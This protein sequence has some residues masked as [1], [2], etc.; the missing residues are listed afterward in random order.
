LSHECFPNSFQNLKPK[1]ICTSQLTG[2]CLS[3][4]ILKLPKSVSLGFSLRALNLSAKCRLLTLPASNS[5]MINASVLRSRP[6]SNRYCKDDLFCFTNVTI[7]VPWSDKG[8]SHA[9]SNSKLR[10]A[11][12][13]RLHCSGHL[14]AQHSNLRG[15]LRRSYKVP[16]GAHGRLRNRLA[17]SRETKP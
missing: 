3:I 4:V 8:G 13:Y 7:T 15:S 5:S 14:R 16:L 11:C 12:W 2:N 10:K 1:W 9:Y 6:E 17:L